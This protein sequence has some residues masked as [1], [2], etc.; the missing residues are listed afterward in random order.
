MHITASNKVKLPLS[1]FEETYCE[2]CGTNLGRILLLQKLWYESWTLW[3]IWVRNL[4][5]RHTIHIIASNTEVLPLSSFEET[6]CEIC[7]T[8]WARIFVLQKLWYDIWT[9]SRIWLRNLRYIYRINITASKTVVRLW[10]IFGNLGVKFAI[11]THDAHYYI[12]HGGTTLQQFRKTGCE[13]CGTDSGQI[14]Q[15]QKL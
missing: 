6:D 9:V 11:E 2:I 10:K 8:D 15:L 12:K 3:G 13:I 5:Y 7:S 1:S 14:L 4:R